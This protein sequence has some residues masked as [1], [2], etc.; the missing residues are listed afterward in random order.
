ML[1]AAH[2][3]T[4]SDAPMSPSPP[5]SNLKFVQGV[6]T[7]VIIGRAGSKGFPNKNSALLNGIPM[8]HYSIKSAL[9][10]RTITS[11]L[12]S[13]DCP[14][15]AEASREFTQVTIVNRPLEL[16]T[17]DASVHATVRH[18]I[19]STNDLSPIVVVLYANVPIRPDTLIDD[20]VTL[21]F[22]SNADSVQSYA[23]VGKHHPAWMSRIQ[24][25]LP[26]P[27]LPGERAHRRQ[28][29]E[30]LYILDGGIIT[31]SRNLLVTEDLAHRHAFLG[32]NRRAIITQ[33]GAVVDIDNSFDMLLAETM[34]MHRQHDEVFV[35]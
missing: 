9:Q 6:A 33:P 8:V 18:A 22:K 4:R 21:H 32:R 2:D 30:P 7:A 31:V 14:G 23:P 13:T 12:V 17:D 19:V 20:A 28:D 3:D 15:L 5:S 25:S 16:A 29:L 24:G 1:R 35:P 34:I 27:Y 10:A 26:T 11:I